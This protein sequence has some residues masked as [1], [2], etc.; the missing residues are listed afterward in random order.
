MRMCLNATCGSCHQNSRLQPGL[1]WGEESMGCS[2]TGSPDVAATGHST[3]S[4][5]TWT[6]LVPMSGTLSWIV[7]DSARRW[8]RFVGLTGGLLAVMLPAAESPAPTSAAAVS[9]GQP[10]D[11]PR[12]QFVELTHDFGPVLSTTPHSPLLLVRA[13]SIA[14]AEA[15]GD[16][17]AAERLQ[18]KSEIRCN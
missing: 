12:I 18:R 17:S 10:S 13:P 5:R 6:I 1:L 7:S 4:L 15:G 16:T 11:G 14:T 8:L 3:T 9:P 2:P